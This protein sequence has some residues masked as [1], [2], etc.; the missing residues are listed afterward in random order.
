MVLLRGFLGVLEACVKEILSPPLLFIMVFEVSSKMI[1]MVE[2]VCILGFLIGKGGCRISHLQFADDTM[3]FCDANELQL[4]YLRYILCC[5][6]AVSGLKINLAKNE[7]FHV[8]EIPNIRDLDWILGCKISSL[9]SFY[10]GLPLGANFK[11]KSVWG[12]VL[13]RITARLDSWKAALL[14]KGGRLT[15][16]KSTFASIPNYFLSL[17]TIPG[18]VA[19]DIKTQFW[20]FL[21]NDA[22]E[23]HR[24]HLMDWKTSCRPLGYGG[25]GI[26]SIR[27]H[28]RVM[29]AKWL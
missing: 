10:L 24:Y 4:G 17:F 14:P 21:W 28:N 26:R 12:P 5:F 22:G 20:N 18:S 19:N 23:H 9:A 27:D 16:L 29:L 6:D 8:G 3:I 7:I 13:E 2:G 11:S 25:L 15:L 1:R